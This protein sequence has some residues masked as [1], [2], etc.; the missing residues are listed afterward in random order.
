MQ[1]PELL[2]AKPRI[3]RAGTGDVAARSIEAVNEAD[4]DRIGAAR[5]HDRDRRGRGFGGESRGYAARRRD[6]G[7]RPVYEIGRQFRQ[8]IVIAVGPTVFDRHVAA[9]DIAGFTEALTECGQ[10]FCVCLG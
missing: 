10:V 6:D 4:F 2:R 3:Y 8:P 7:H 9:L 5:V 1:K